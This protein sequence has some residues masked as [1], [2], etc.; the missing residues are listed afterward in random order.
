MTA[1]VHHLKYDFLNGLRDRSLLLMN[2]LFPLA[3]FVMMGALLGGINPTFHETMVPSLI[4]IA[5]MTSTLLG[6]PNPIVSSREAGVFRSYKINGVPAASILSIP[7]LSSLL[8]MILVSAIITLAAVLLFKASLPTHW[9]YFI[10]VG[11][12][13]IFAMAGIGM[14][15][16]VIA[17]NSRATILISQFFFV[18][19]M[20][21]SGMVMPSSMLPAN[22]QRIAM[23]LPATH[24]M[25]AW[26]SLAFGQSAGVNPLWSILVLLAGGL[27]AFCLAVI[28][29]QWDSHN[30]QRGRSPVMAILALIPYLLAAIFLR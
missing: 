6:M 23:L 3:L 17:S 10:L 11:L 16:G 13:T 14:L 27:I 4:I 20:M 19:S 8:H 21:L 30:Q 22:M 7:V 29:F 25:N 18:P 12:L 2:Y 1:F 5:V 28:L 24:A 15:I 26:R 9:G